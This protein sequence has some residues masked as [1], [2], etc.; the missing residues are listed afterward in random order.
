MKT[1]RKM[2]LVQIVLPLADQNGRAFPEDLYDTLAADLTEAF[3]GVTSY[4]RSPAEGRW[5]QGSTTQRDGI[6]VVE[7]AVDELDRSYWK[8]LRR[9]LENDFKQDEIMLR[10]QVAE[11]L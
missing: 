2:Y 7:V 10:A 1:G 3:G 9:R 11:R 4:L 6:A 8:A 5:K